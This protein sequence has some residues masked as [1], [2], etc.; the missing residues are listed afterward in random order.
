MDVLK[1]NVINNIYIIA[2]MATIFISALNVT[3]EL[4]YSNMVLVFLI[5]GVVCFF[6]DRLYRFS[7]AFKEQ[8]IICIYTLFLSMAFIAGSQVHY[9]AMR[10]SIQE[11]Y[12]DLNLSCVFT[13]L[14][15]TILLFP[16][17]SV[18]AQLIKRYVIIESDSKSKFDWKFFLVSGGGILLAWIPYLLTFYPGGVV[19][20][21]A[22][23]LEMSLQSG[24]PNHNH[25]VVFYILILRFFLWIGRFI[26]VDINVGIFLYAIVESLIYAA[27]CAAVVTM[28]RK[29][30]IPALFCYAAVC[31]YALSGFFASYS[32][33]LWKDGIFSSG[34]VLLALLLWEFP[35]C[36]R[37]TF[38]YMIKF[39]LISLFLCFCRNN[40]IY[41][42]ILCIIGMAF[43]LK[44]NGR[45][46][47]TAGSLV[48]CFSMFIQGPVY[49][50]AGIGKDS[51]IESLSVPLQQIAA[52]VNDGQELTE[53]QAE[54]V[55]SLIPKEIWIENYCPTLSDDLKSATDT[56][57]LEEHLGDFF[58]VWFQLLIPNFHTYVKSYLMQMLGFWQIGVFKGHYSDYWL[59]VEDL[60]GRGYA[61]RDL[62][63]EVTGISIKPF[64]LSRMQFIP[65]GSMV[66][67]TFFSVAAILCQTW[68]RRK[69]L[70]VLLPFIA[71]WAIVMVAAPIAYAYRYIVMLPMAFPIIFSMPFMNGVKNETIKISPDMRKID[72]KAKCALYLAL[73]V[74]IVSMCINFRENVHVI[75]KYRGG[76]FVIDLAGKQD[77]ADDYVVEGLS[78]NEGAFRWTDG[79]TVSFKIPVSKKYQEVEVALSVL[80]TFN[81]R[82]SYIIK[83]N[84]H[85]LTQGTLNG[86]GEIVF[87]VDIEDEII[88]FDLYLPDAQV[89]NEVFPEN[90]DKRKVSFQ[91]DKIILKE[92]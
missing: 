65:S 14:S 29:K 24:V 68:N 34:I 62:I 92:Q 25:W 33:T 40:G 18:I 70:L 63:C 35:L 80:D 23:T 32:M 86:A 48:V 87:G 75:R 73:A 74:A 45:L 28:V 44:K 82:R 42:V 46:L 90:G 10:S 69:R 91:V 54:I 21:G 53:Y 77:R 49:D 8:S 22:L 76:E 17:L 84:E 7:V 81:G 38:S 30:G 41:V 61:E 88:S 39:I 15:L 72:T 89:I 20:D 4:G 50:M 71:S 52:V 83:Q 58:K 12:I 5:M 51:L 16:I 9:E 37:P 2:G 64:L 85:I 36:E 26:S 13:G 11:N 57:Y 3:G 47:I 79:N 60:L 6:Y 27:V 19:G 78:A 31:V 59:G 66:W 1:K 55:Y 43:L 56:E 67:I